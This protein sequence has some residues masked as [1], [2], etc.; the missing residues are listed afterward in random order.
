MVESKPEWVPERIWIL[1]L[2]HKNTNCIWE[3][4]ANAPEYIQPRPNTQRAILD[5]GCRCVWTAIESR[6]DEG[7]V[8]TIFDVID[9]AAEGPAGSH[10]EVPHAVRRSLGNKVARLSGALRDALREV[11]ESARSSQGNMIGE[12]ST[13]R[14]PLE[15]WSPLERAIH[16]IAESHLGREVPFPVSVAFSKVS[17]GFDSVLAGLEVGGARW[18]ETRPVVTARGN[19]P[20]RLYFIREMTRWFRQFFSTPLREQVAAL[21]RCIYECDMDA[22]TVAKLA[23]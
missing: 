10:A 14:L 11:A 21:T 4:C 3:Q 23:P 17:R 1:W 19:D 6:F 18:A 9:D 2:D 12:D 7:A 20:R 8:R 15:M 22:A 13:G 5:V 16:N